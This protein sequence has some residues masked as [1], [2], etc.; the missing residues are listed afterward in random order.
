MKIIYT[1][2]ELSA[3]QEAVTEVSMK[4]NELGITDTIPYQNL[5]DD[6]L[7]SDEDWINTSEDLNG[8]ITV[9]IYVP[10]VIDIFGTYK[11]IILEI[12]TLVK[13]IMLAMENIENR[14]AR[15]VS[16]WGQ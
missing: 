15:F 10:F 16:I 8:N 2:E 14:F 6:L 9:E 4:I 13:P 1:A 3:L 11:D 7:A 5:R 12:L